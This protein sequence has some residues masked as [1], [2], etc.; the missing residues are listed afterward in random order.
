MDRLKQLRKEKKWTQDCVGSLIGVSKNTVSRYE[1]GTREP[2]FETL[3]KLAELFAVSTDYL[4]GRTDTP[5]DPHYITLSD[6]VVATETVKIETI[7]LNEE[8]RRLERIADM[9]TRCNDEQID[10]LLGMLIQ[11]VGE[12][13]E[14]APR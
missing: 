3:T 11:M 12:Q 13:K 2:D 10:I 8:D 5:D 9:L 6:N 7:T 14:K 4:L 1:K